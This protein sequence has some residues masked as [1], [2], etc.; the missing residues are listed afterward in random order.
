MD[1]YNPDSDLPFYYTEVNGQTDLNTQ[2]CDN[3]WAK[4]DNIDDAIDYSEGYADDL[5]TPANDDIWTVDTTTF[6]LLRLPDSDQVVGVALNGVLLF[7][8][9]S[10]YGYDAFFP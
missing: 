1:E 3:E 2:L 8:G 4:H 10:D 6:P 9:T 7:S 5:L